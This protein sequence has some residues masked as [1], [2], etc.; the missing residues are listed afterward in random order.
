MARQACLL[1]RDTSV[2]ISVVVS[3][4]LFGLTLVA[5]L[6]RYRWYLRLLLHE[7][8]RGGGEGRRRRQHAE[9]F[10]YDVFVSY[11]ERDLFWMRRW[12]LPELE[13]RQGLRLCVH[14]RDF[15]PGEPRQGTNK[16]RGYTV[17]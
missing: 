11:S 3:L 16:E 15:I 2:F 7:A 9:N 10:D 6:F 5:V 14:Q 13:Q 12:L 17:Y 1:G 4:L 8:F